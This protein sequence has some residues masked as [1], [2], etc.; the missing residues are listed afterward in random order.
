MNITAKSGWLP[1]AFMAAASILL[2]VVLIGFNLKPGVS[3]ETPTTKQAEEKMSAPKE[4]RVTGLE[5]GRVDY[6]SALEEALRETDPQK[7]G[8]A[9]GTAFA[10][11]LDDDVE[12]ALG[13]VR[14]MGQGPQYDEALFMVL[15]RISKKDPARALSLAGE[16]AT[17]A[18]QREIYHP[19]MVQMA[20]YNLLAAVDLIPT[21]PA[22]ESRDNAIST[23]AS[24]WSDKDSNAALAWAQSLSDDAER[25]IALEVCACSLASEDP[26]HAFS[27]AT[28]SLSGDALER[29]ADIGLQRM[30][31]TNPEA[32]SKIVP[33]LPEGELQLH[34]AMNVARA[35]AN[36]GTDTALAWLPSLPAGPVRQAALNN[37]LDIWQQQNPADAAAYVAQ[38]PAGDD[39]NAAVAHISHALGAAD[40][41]YAMQWI[42]TLPSDDARRAAVENIVSGWAE[43]DPAGATLWAQGL[44]AD[45]PNRIEVLRSAYSYW[46]LI[47][48]HEAAAFAASLPAADGQQLAGQ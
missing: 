30:L 25:K 26:Q 4:A 34:V 13:Y 8:I 27:V 11:W 21:I 38:M 10:R 40:P 44:P 20:S 19:L 12:G 28:E 23:V 39:Q 36:E 45:S 46:Q 31:Q 3:T 5:N 41:D 16:M 42:Q 47:D 14:G 7:R 48:A 2:A 6:R 37:V 22:G 24:M 43:H 33:Q 29:V 9:F 18:E 35:L 32:A 1:A 15:K 17:T